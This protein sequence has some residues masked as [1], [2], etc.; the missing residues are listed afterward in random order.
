MIL[1]MAV[2]WGWVC[3]NRNVIQLPLLVKE[4]AKYPKGP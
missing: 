4:M 3:M 2:L 1:V